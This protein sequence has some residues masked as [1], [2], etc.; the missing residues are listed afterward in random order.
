[1]NASPP[2]KGSPRFRVSPVASVLFLIAL[3]GYLVVEH[4][5]HLLLTL[6]GLPYLFLLAC[7][8][9][10]LF[11]HGRHRHRHRGD[12]DRSDQHPTGSQS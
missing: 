3:V 8:L 1:M 5:A 6:G 4:R 9:L 10:H 7:P 12:P 2:Q 11:H